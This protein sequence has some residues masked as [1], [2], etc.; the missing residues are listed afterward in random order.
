MRWSGWSRSSG[1]RVNLTLC[2]DR[3]YCYIK[4]KGYD[5]RYNT[6][7]PKEHITFCYNYVAPEEKED[8]PEYPSPAPAATTTK[9]NHNHHY[10]TRGKHRPKDYRQALDSEEKEDHTNLEDNPQE[11]H[12]NSAPISNPDD[13]NEL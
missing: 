8:D 4:W 9:T 5:E 7:E 13:L 6:W 11:L 12:Q 10:H 1:S 2:L 3:Q